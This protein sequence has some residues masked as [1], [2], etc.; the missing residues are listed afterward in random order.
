M[1]VSARKINKKLYKIQKFSLRQR[2]KIQKTGK[3]NFR[4]PSLINA[5]Q[6]LR[7]QAQKNT[8]H[9]FRGRV[10]RK[11]FFSACKRAKFVSDGAN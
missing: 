11:K 5:S 4:S 1:L 9:F 3:A 8:N 6:S 2:P 10:P 7:P